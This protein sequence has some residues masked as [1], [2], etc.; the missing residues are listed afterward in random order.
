MGVNLI[1]SSELVTN[2]YGFWPRFEGA[3]VLAVSVETDSA[4]FYEFG[5]RTLTIDIHWWLEASD[6]YPGGPIV[7]NEKDLHRRIRMAFSV[8]DIRIHTF[9]C[10]DTSINNLLIQPDKR[11]LQCDGGFELSCKYSEA[12]VLLAEPC[13]E[14]GRTL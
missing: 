5:E 3:F 8:E 12:R 4:R 2:I 10:D 14:I 11:Q 1:D 6:H 7:F 13:D 9:H